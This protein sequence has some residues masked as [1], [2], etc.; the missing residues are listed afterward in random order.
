[1]KRNLMLAI[2]AI[3]LA[4]TPALSQSSSGKTN[5]WTQLKSELRLD[6]ASVSIGVS[7]SFMAAP[8]PTNF[9]LEEY[10][11]YRGSNFDATLAVNVWRNMNL[12]VGLGY[13]SS[14]NPENY[15]SQ[16]SDWGTF[17][18]LY[19]DANE[20]VGKDNI[21]G[22]SGTNLLLGFGVSRSLY[23]GKFHVTPSYMRWYGTSEGQY[24]ID[25]YRVKATGEYVDQSA[26]IH[27]EPEIDYF[28]SLGLDFEFSKHIL[29]FYLQG[30][31]D[32]ITGYAVR[33]GYKL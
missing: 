2:V 24:I 4:S 16:Y 1:M 10:M 23:F 28:E 20:G 21:F 3:G 18:S 33:Y 29:G 19:Q 6:P 15:Y 26:L 22:L 12:R 14:I 13:L 31:F 11:N 27:W 17:E 7:P 25:G 30:G 8:D 32:N 5:A 9:T